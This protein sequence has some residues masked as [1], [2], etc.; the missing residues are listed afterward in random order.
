MVDVVDFTAKATAIEGLI[1]LTVKQVT[2]ERGTVR[3]FFRASTHAS[4]PS[5]TDRPAGRVPGPWQQVN[6]T[7]TGPGAIRGLHGEDM[8]KLV[9]VAAGTALGV[10][11]DARPTSPSYGDVVTFDLVPGVEVLVP[12]GVCNGFQATGPEGCVYLYC[13]DDE[14]R[15]DMGGVAFSPC[16]PGLP[17]TWPVP[18]D[19]DD[20]CQISVKD[21]DAPRFSAT[22]ITPLDGAS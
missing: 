9:G 6:V 7:T 22:R 3:E 1:C 19:V 16:D 2:D 14:W 20:R 10:Y 4:V 11:L 15:P 21:R 12:P 18:V 17:V 8:F 5:S 13:F